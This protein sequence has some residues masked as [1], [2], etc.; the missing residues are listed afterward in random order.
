MRAWHRHTG[1]KL[2]EKD[3]W[4]TRWGAR[5]ANWASEEEKEKHGGKA[6]SEHFRMLHTAMIEAIN[7]EAN[8]LQPRNAKA[9]YNKA[10]SIFQKLVSDRKRNTP[11]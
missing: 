4:I 6:R 2:D 11:Q 7:H 9:I 3:P 8:K 1:E 5:W 10:Q